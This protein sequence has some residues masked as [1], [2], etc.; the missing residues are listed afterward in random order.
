MNTYENH[1]GRKLAQDAPL[2]ANLPDGIGK[3]CEVIPKEKSGAY[4]ID[5]SDGGCDSDPTA[6]A[7]FLKH[8]KVLRRNSDLPWLK[9]HEVLEIEPGDAISDS[10]T[11]IWN[12]M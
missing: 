10:G 2:A 11:E 5:Q 12:L 3:W 7:A 6:Q 9:E 1:P 4:P 8:L